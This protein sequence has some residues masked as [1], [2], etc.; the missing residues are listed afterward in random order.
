MFNQINQ[1]SKKLDGVAIQTIIDGLKGSVTVP[2]H[3][4]G[5][6]LDMAISQAKEKYFRQKFQNTHSEILESDL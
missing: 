3:L 2:E 4:K 5:L 1:T 6:N